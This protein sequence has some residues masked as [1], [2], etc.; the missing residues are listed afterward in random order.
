MALLPRRRAREATRQEP[1][2]DEPEVVVRLGF[3]TS[4]PACGGRGYLDHID[5]TRH[6]QRQHCL[7]CGRTWEISEDG[8][9]D[10]R[11]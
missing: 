6:S 7:T 3:A 4:C 11:E 5:V 1:P 9:I 10:L 8:V 2:V